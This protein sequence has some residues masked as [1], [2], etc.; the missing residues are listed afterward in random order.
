MKDVIVT[1]TNLSNGDVNDYCELEEIHDNVYVDVENKSVEI[2][3][4]T[5][6]Q[7]QIIPSLSSRNVK[8]VGDHVDKMKLIEKQLKVR[9]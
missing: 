2:T 4:P 8:I 3:N 5:D 7:L 9:L 1:I 6:Y